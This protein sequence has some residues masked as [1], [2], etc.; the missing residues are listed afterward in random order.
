MLINLL[1]FFS[2]NMTSIYSFNINTLN[3]DTIHLNDYQGKKILLV[4]I[5][6][7][8]EYAS[9]LSELQALYNQFDNR[10]IVIAF[11]S[12]SF[13]HEPL[14]NA[15]VMQFIADST[16][17]SFPVAELSEVTGSDANPIYNW[18]S[19]ANENGVMDRITMHD[20]QK[21]LISEDGKIIA[22]FQNEIS[23]LDPL[24]TDAINN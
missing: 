17:I 15:A 12:N 9:Q 20:Y 3:Q 22:V 2:L 19:Q 24:I 10:L 1:L 14:T 18:L 21:V 23:P 16:N 5:A 8:S 13:E 11:P 7:G 6:S 4:N